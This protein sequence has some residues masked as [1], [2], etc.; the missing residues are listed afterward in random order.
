MKYIP[1]NVVVFILLSIAVGLSSCGESVKEKSQREKIDSL[2]N[3]NYQNKL[4]YDDLNRYLYV[5]ADGL[6]SISQAEGM[7]LVKE[8]G[9]ERRGLN[10]QRLQQNIE[11]IRETLS[12]HRERIL[13]LEKNLTSTT[14]HQRDYTLL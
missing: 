1:L 5:I 12:R 4:S 7:L 13:D 2:E 11:K 3:E 6:D 14:L 9:I 10:R 8:G